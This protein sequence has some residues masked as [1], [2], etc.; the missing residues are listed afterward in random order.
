MG[1]LTA[2][3]YQI[4]TPTELNAD[5]TSQA[6]ALVPGFTTLPSELRTNLIQEA[7]LVAYK[8]ENA[9]S[10][11]MNGIAPGYANDF[12]F[13]QFGESFGL[14]PKEAINAQVTVVFTGPVGTYIPVGTTC[15]NAGSTIQ[16]ATTVDG[17]IGSTGNISILCESTGDQEITILA[18]TITVLDVAITGVTIDNPNAGTAGLPAETAAEYRLRVQQALSATRIGQIERIYELLYQVPGV[19]PRLVTINHSTVTVVTA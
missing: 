1:T 12:M 2:S 10:D 18:N 9:I 13:Q 6:V 4:S 11:L 17:I 7:S 14:P 8:M 5:L 19:T 15:S 3:G 16:V